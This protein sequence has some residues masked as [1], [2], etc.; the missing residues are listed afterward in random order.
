MINES[1]ASVYISLLSFLFL[2]LPFIHGFWMD[3]E[4]YVWLLYR[5][6]HLPVVLK[7]LPGCSQAALLSVFSVLQ[8]ISSLAV[9]RETLSCHCCR[10]Y[11]SA[12]FVFHFKKFHIP[13]QI[14]R[15]RIEHKRS[16][17]MKVQKMDKRAKIMST[18]KSVNDGHSL[19]VLH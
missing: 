10:E 19:C 5:R 15:F 13:C 6:C 7:L 1:L 12:S 4:G 8:N 16:H 9:K 17:N 18:W 14:R 2:S 3:A 11:S